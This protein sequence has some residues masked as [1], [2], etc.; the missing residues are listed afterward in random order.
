MYIQSARL[1]LTPHNVPERR[2]LVAESGWVDA[3]TPLL[4][5]VARRGRRQGWEY[6]V[7]FRS[8]RAEKRGNQQLLALAAPAGASAVV[9]VAPE[10]PSPLAED[11][12]R[13]VLDVTR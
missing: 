9:A 4:C 13:E 7:V 6:V 1:E 5:P 8:R 3:G 12:A 10:L 2:E 11:G